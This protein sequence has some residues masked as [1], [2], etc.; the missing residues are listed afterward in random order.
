[1][2]GQGTPVFDANF[3]SMA[4][5]FDAFTHSLIRC[6]RSFPPRAGHRAPPEV[7]LEPPARPLCDGIL[8]SAQNDSY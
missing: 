8:R 7:P 2:S 3:F 6:S 4:P 5:Y 1:M